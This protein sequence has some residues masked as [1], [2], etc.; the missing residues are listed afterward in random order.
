MNKNFDPRVDAYIAKSA[1]FAQPILR[2]LRKLVHEACPTATETIKWTFP[3]FEHH[4]ILCGMAAF[5]AHCTFGFW[6]QG[7]TKVLGRDSKKG[8]E[9]MGSLGRITSVGDLPNEKTMLHYIRQAAK[10]KE[11]GV[12]ARPVRKPRPVL[13]VPADLAV[14]LKKNKAAAATFE[15]FSPSHR[16]DYIEWIMEAK[17]EETRGKRLATTLE[18]L[19]EGKS[20]NWKY[21]NC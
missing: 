7:V 19:A 2:H 18:W 17:R 6:H 14:A 12:P 4:G 13:A 15:K 9:A 20:R 21:E 8:E 16:R 1:D 10:L 3:T 11:T 5:K